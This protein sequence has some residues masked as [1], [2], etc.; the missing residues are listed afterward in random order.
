MFNVYTIVAAACALGLCTTWGYDTNTTVDSY[1]A[2]DPTTV[3]EVFLTPTQ[4]DGSVSM[5][6][7]ADSG[8]TITV[9]SD[10]TIAENVEMDSATVISAEE[11]E[12]VNEVYLT[13]IQVGENTYEYRDANGEL[14]A[15]LVTTDDSDDNVSAI[16]SDKTTR[17][18]RWLSRPGEIVQSNNSIDITSP[19]VDIEYD[20]RFSPSGLSRLGY[21]SEGSQQY[22]WLDVRSTTRFHGTLSI[23]GSHPIYLAIKN[24]CDNRIT[25]YGEYSF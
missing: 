22:S 17:S 25:Y 11:A 19:G 13:P 14:V 20:I 8:V 12:N 5:Y 18:I 21:Y 24:E 9:I 4:A 23:S 16:A 15:T 6:E 2:V 3:E 10:D 1:V 7:D